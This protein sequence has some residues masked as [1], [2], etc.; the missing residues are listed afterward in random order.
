[1]AELQNLSNIWFKSV[2]S[3][4]EGD[5]LKSVVVRAPLGVVAGL[6]FSDRV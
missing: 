2:V 4:S 5:A 6:S 1:M 3:L